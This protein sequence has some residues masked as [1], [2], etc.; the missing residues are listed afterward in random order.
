LPII[1]GQATQIFQRPGDTYVILK[2]AEPA[3]IYEN[4]LKPSADADADPKDQ[5]HP[6]VSLAYGDYTQGF[7][8]P[9]IQR[10]TNGIFL[11]NFIRHYQAIDAAGRMV[12]LVLYE[13][14]NHVF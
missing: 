4:A 8:P 11:S 9:L 13:G 10:G 5:K 14:M 6:C 7:P 1:L 12:K 2:H 3:Y